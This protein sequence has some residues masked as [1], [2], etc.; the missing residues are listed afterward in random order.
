MFIP[1]DGNIC[2]ESKQAHALTQKFL[3]GHVPI[4]IP[5]KNSIGWCI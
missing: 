4:E 3:K 1:N 5:P 2:Q